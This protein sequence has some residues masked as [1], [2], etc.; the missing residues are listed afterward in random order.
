[1]RV[2]APV[3]VIS[4]ANNDVCCTNNMTALL[5]MSNTCARPCHA[6]MVPVLVC[7]TNAEMGTASSSSPCGMRCMYVMSSWVVRACALKMP[8][9]V[10]LCELTSQNLWTFIHTLHIHDIILLV[11]FMHEYE[12]P[13]CHTII[14]SP[15][16]M[17]RAGQANL[18][19]SSLIEDQCDGE[20]VDVH[21]RAAATCLVVTNVPSV[22][23]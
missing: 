18:D 15:T 17:G 12:Y 14:H 2:R 1:M 21:V 3:S 6:T 23:S 11:Q 4:K 10:I 13:V 9:D 19:A 8:R 22:M 5:Q 7:V 20:W 16:A